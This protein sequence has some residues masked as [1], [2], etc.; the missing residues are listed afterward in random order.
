MRRSYT[1]NLIVHGYLGA[2][3][4]VVNR[5][6]SIDDRRSK[7]TG[8]SSFDFSFIKR[9][10]F[11]PSSHIDRDSSRVF[12]SFFSSGKF[13]NWRICELIYRSKRGTVTAAVVVRSKQARSGIRFIR[14]SRCLE[15]RSFAMRFPV[16]SRRVPAPDSAPRTPRPLFLS[17]APSVPL[18]LR[19]G[20][21]T[22]RASAPMNH[23][24][25]HLH[26]LCNFVNT[27]FSALYYCDDESRQRCW[28]P[29]TATSR[30]NRHWIKNTVR[31]HRNLLLFIVIFSFDATGGIML[32]DA[33]QT[34][35]WMLI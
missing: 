13:R 34:R 16:P 10:S 21:Q 7:F 18:L 26:F 6:Y 22:T 29:P 20:G 2:D 1:R 12:D 35:H 5:F 3:F 27:R 25:G 33:R 14:F 32:F 8:L 19:S 23:R 11:E 31:S 24:P 15:L 9:K 28:R 30:T 4:F 17:P